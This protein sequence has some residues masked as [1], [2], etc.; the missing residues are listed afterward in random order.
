MLATFFQQLNN[1]LQKFHSL[2]RIRKSSES[3]LFHIFTCSLTNLLA[4]THTL[5]ACDM[6]VGVVVVVYSSFAF[7]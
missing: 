3:N 4:H 1:S 7:T 5:W 6:G 2:Q